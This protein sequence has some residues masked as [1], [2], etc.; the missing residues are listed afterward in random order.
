MI[1]HLLTIYILNSWGILVPLVKDTIFDDGAIDFDAD[2]LASLLRALPCN[3][4]GL[5]VVG[6]TTD[7][8]FGACISLGEVEGREEA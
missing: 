3:R 6:V 8:L 4:C 7:V 2:T 1:T 5:L